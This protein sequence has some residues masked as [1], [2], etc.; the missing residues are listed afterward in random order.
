MTKQRIIQV[1]AVAGI[2]AYLASCTYF[3]SDWPAVK[4]EKDRKPAPDFALTDADGKVAKLS[5]YRGKVVLLNFWATWCGPCEV[6]IPWFIQFQREYQDR[7]FAVLGV[8][9]DEDGWKAVKPFV[10]RERVNYRMVITSELV[11]QQYGGI[12]HL[13]T[14]FVIDRE[15]RVASSHLGLVSMKTYRQEILTL[16]GSPKNE[17]PPL[18][19][20]NRMPAGI[21]A[22]LLPAGQLRTGH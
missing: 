5:D 22:D 17:K 11:S 15:G 4:A 3:E 10:A 14:T 6:E 20:D 1:L 21:W 16:L 13:P 7:D 18:V 2:A 12:D 19:S 8:S 9:E